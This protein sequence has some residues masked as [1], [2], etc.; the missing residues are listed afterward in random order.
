M[1]RARNSFAFALLEYLTLLS[2]VHS[3]IHH[4]VIV[5]CLT[6]LSSL[7]LPGRIGLSYWFV[8][9]NHNSSTW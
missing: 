1:Y 7:A 6:I 8:E 4:K 5:Q 3:S 2:V 9:C